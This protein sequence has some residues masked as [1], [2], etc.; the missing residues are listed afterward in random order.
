MAGIGAIQSR[1]SLNDTRRRQATTVDASG[2]QAYSNFLACRGL[3][4]SGM[5][6]SFTDIA[7]DIQDT[8]DSVARSLRTAAEKLSGDA[9]EGVS[10]GAEDAT[11]AS[12]TVRKYATSTA[13]KAAREAQE[14]PLAVAAIITAAAALVALIITATR[15]R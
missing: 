7:Q 3:R 9:G 11:R 12:E 15:E 5:R 14:H 6:N 8:L 13:K 1:L 10:R 4:V 2:R